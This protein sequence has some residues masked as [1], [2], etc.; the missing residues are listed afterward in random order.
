IRGPFGGSGLMTDRELHTGTRDETPGDP[1]AGV[2]ADLDALAAYVE[3]LTT[4]PRSPHRGPARALTAQAEAGRIPF[5]S[6]A[7]SCT[8]CH[9]GA[10]LT[11]S[12]FVAPAE[13]L[14][15]DVGTIT[16]ASGQRLGGPLLGIDTPTLVELWNTPP[17][18]HDGSATTLLD[19]LT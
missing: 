16:P 3:S 6:P 10:S 8:T 5:Q 9:A 14:L 18:L 12:Q 11:D 1:K 15:H 13:A 2:S 4:L 17:Y 19:V 7:L